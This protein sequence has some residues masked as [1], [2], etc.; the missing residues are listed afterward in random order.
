M[1]KKFSVWKNLYNISH[2]KF[3]PKCFKFLQK[4]FFAGTTTIPTLTP[5][6]KTNNPKFFIF[7]QKVFSENDA[8]LPWR[9]LGYYNTSDPKIMIF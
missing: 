2:L 5:V 9:E 1:P 4:N 8:G 7:L 6:S 3:S